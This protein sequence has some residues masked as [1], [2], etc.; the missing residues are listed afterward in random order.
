MGGIFCIVSE[1][2]GR[3]VGERRMRML[4]D[5][6]ARGAR[7][8]F[9]NAHPPGEVPERLY[10]IPRDLLTALNDKALLP[11]LVPA[12]A[13]PPRR[14]VSMEEAERLQLAPDRTL[15]IKGSTPR[16]TGAGGA[17]VM[18]RDRDM[19]SR[20]RLRLPGC[21]RVVAGVM[22]ALPPRPPHVT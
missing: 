14:V 10:W 16:S 11:R 5:L 6:A 17:V 2:S 1:T 7:L 15:V 4:R 22:A 8:A 12:E 13:Y 20:L 18:V 21:D 3:V 9:H 19:L